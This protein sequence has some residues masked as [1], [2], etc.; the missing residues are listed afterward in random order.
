[1][2]KRSQLHN[3]QV[4]SVEYILQTKKEGAYHWLGAGKTIISLT[5]IVDLLAEGKIKRALVIAPLRVA[6]T[7]WHNEIQNWEHT[8]HLRWSIVTGT[9]KQRTEA[10]AKDAD[11][12][13]INQENTQW[14]FQTGKTKWGM[15]VIDESSAF[16]NPSAKRF[17]ALKKFQYNYMVQLSA[18]PFP[19]GPLGIWS[20]MY[21]LDKGER[22]GKAYYIYTSNYFIPD[23]SGYNM[24][25]QN[26]QAI[27][28]KISDITM[29]MKAEDYLE[30]PP[31]IMINTKVDIANQYLYKEFKREFI[32]K[33][34][35][36]EVVA[37]NAAVLTGKL[38]QFCNGA[39]YDENKNIL[40]IHDSK[41]DALEDIIEENKH[42]NILVAYNFKSDLIR[43]Q[44]RFKDAV[45][46]DTQGSQVK[47]WNEGKIKLL[48]CHPA[49]SGKGLNLQAGGSII[50]WFGLTW[51]LEDYLQ[52]N[53]RLHRQ[54]QTKPVIINHI[55]ANGCIDE[56]V[57]Q[58]LQ[59]KEMCLNG[60]LDFLKGGL[61]SSHP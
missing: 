53:G 39:I 13:I 51:N 29:S 24:I 59:N 31:K 25:C 15:I 20:Q 23:H 27:Y 52:F 5:A 1:M 49:S 30:L 16:K 4:R 42:D 14:L 22:L 12:Y 46:M 33:V 40:E 57:M 8:Q 28:D 36:K 21:L 7:V 58:M 50:V 11:I 43:L 2:L 34:Q 41:L 10:L 3:Y 38:L 18:T 55:I 44:R 60:L 35:N 48:L 6:N 61:T 56:K 9:D 47:P 19:N 32:T 37:Q 45:V 17:K 54:G 26:E